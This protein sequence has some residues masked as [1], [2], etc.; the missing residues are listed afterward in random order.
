MKEQEERQL[1][2]CLIAEGK[3]IKAHLAVIINPRKLDSFV[4][5]WHR[6]VCNLI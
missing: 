1:Q 6:G 3:N 2:A 5:F 4:S